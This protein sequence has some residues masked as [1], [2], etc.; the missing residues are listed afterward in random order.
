MQFLKDNLIEVER[1][2]QP[3]LTRFNWNSLG[4][5]EYAKDCNEVLK[6]LTSIVAQ[7]E[8]LS[9]EV[10]TRIHSLENFNLFF[11]KKP[12]LDTPLLSC[13]VLYVQKLKQRCQI[14]F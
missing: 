12:D 9:Q 8:K 6:N 1:Q 10:Q 4:I 2:I 13:K 3:G 7:M 14:Y 5:E 11:L